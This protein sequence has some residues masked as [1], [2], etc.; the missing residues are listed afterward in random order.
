LAD[1]IIYVGDNVN[2]DLAKVLKKIIMLYGGFYLDV[3]SPIITHILTEPLLEQ[4]YG[5]LKIYGTLVSLVRV[6]WLIDSIYLN[7]RMKE[8]DYL[9]RSFKSRI[10]STLH[11]E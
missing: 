8:E 3:L 9:I 2:V 1:T 6:E 7:K 11:L 4:E 10:N 5:E